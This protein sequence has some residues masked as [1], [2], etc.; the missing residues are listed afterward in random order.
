MKRTRR[1]IKFEVRVTT[2][3]IGKIKSVFNTVVTVS[4]DMFPSQ[5]WKTATVG[6]NHSHKQVYD[7]CNTLKHSEWKPLDDILWKLLTES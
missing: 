5:H 1:V 2:Y 3:Y 6:G 4:S 7:T